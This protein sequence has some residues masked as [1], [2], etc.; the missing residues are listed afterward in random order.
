MEKPTNSWPDT[1]KARNLLFVGQAIKQLA[2]IDAF[3][4]FRMMTL[5]TVS[6]ISEAKILVSDIQKGLSKHTFA[7]VAKELCWSIKSDPVVDHKNHDQIAHALKY[8]ESLSINDNTDMSR[9]YSKLDV[10]SAK[11]SHDYKSKLETFILA[12]YNIASN[13]S[14]TISA[15]CH[16]LAFLV[17]NKYSRQYIYDTADEI[18][19]LE[20]VG[21]ATNVKIREFFNKFDLKDY[22][23]EV[24]F[25]VDALAE[26]YL[27]DVY[28]LTVVSASDVPVAVIASYVMG[29][30]KIHAVNKFARVD[31]KAKDMFTAARQTYDEMTSISSVSVISAWDFSLPLPKEFCSYYK[32]NQTARAYSIN[33]IDGGSSV[34]I[35]RSHARGVRES[36]SDTNNI[37]N[38][39]DS[40]SI[41]RLH[42]S[43]S[44]VSSALETNSYDSRLIS[45]W[46]SFESLLSPPPS[47]SVRILHYIDIVSP[48]ILAKYP[49]RSLNSLYNALII[50]N[51]SVFVKLLDDISKDVGANN[52][53]QLTS[54]L[55]DEKYKEKLEA[56]KKSL[57]SYPLLLHRLEVIHDKFST[58]ERYVESLSSHKERVDWQL[59]RIYRARNQLVHAGRA[60][61]YLEALTV[62]SFEYYRNAVRHIIGHGTRL[63]GINDVDTVVESVGLNYAGQLSYVTNLKSAKKF[64]TITLQKV[65]FA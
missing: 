43:I 50:S 6:R 45:I 62:N 32:R 4:S 30:L 8:F 7:P 54:L 39:F 26:P 34:K 42:N 17:N 41:E 65:F 38:N 15:I 59:N 52:S 61:A 19:F 33:V 14:L 2:S 36:K 20:D 12:N 11:I 63:G 40:R 22:K 47:K 16:Y 44:T 23:Y 27:K 9:V 35:A 53:L 51:R 49:E 21:R 10:L 31:K 57:A 37:R 13:R 3:E 18:F 55:F 25:Q 64:T 58:P 60:P 29:G 5:D 48:C 1:V 28:N 24:Y 46:S 56:L